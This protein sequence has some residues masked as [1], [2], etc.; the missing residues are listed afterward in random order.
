[1]IYGFGLGKPSKIFGFVIAQGKG[2]WNSIILLVEDLKKL[3]S[4]K[5]SQRQMNLG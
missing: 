4:F 5:V 1:M 2:V 3:A